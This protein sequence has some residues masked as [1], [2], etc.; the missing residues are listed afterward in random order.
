[1]E[2]N[3]FLSFEQ[4]AGPARRSISGP[5][6]FRETSDGSGLV[7]RG[8]ASTT[9]T[10]YPVYGGTFPGWVETMAAGSFK[11]TLK[12]NADVSFL[13]N[14]DGM[15]LARTK[16]GTLQLNEDQTGLHVE[17]RLNPNVSAVRD[18]YELSRD[19]NMDEMSFGFRVMRE[20]WQNADGEPADQSTGTHRRI[21][22]VNM[23]KGDVSA[24]N[25][26]AN[27]TTAGGFRA[28]AEL[29]DGRI[30]DDALTQLA[31]AVVEERSTVTTAANLLNAIESAVADLRA[32]FAN[33][34]STTP[35]GTPTSW[36]ADAA[37]EE[38]RA[39]PDQ[40]LATYYSLL[41]MRREPAA[42]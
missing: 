6:E 26:G 23:N 22:E 28:L 9:E 36:L 34:D 2:R 25:Y 5:L 29:R 21:L 24:V 19:G 37:P 8:Y 16:A 18:L 12:N 11:R 7:Y 14:H 42:Q 31:R 41:E 35:D 17:A 39:E 33:A 15:A 4:S 1:M 20:E 32:M 40:L 10:E 3:D 13:I 38:V 27:D 30:P